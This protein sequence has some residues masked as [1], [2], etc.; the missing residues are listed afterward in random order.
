M[1]GNDN[2][3]MK[4][5][6]NL[7]TSTILSKIKYPFIKIASLFERVTVSNRIQI[8]ENPKYL[9]AQDTT[10]ST[11]ESSISDVTNEVNE[12]G[13]E[14]IDEYN[15]K[16]PLQLDASMKHLYTRINKTGN[17]KIHRYLPSDEN[18][19]TDQNTKVIQ[20]KKGLPHPFLREM[21]PPRI[22]PKNSLLIQELRQKNVLST[23]LLAKDFRPL[24]ILKE[25]ELF[26]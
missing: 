12:N 8:R 24:S 5:L 26:I 1:K 17:G 25:F 4:I 14:D 19:P 6:N 16:V 9:S 10:R 3:T 18:V 2:K 22:P 7:T 21:A 23:S 20:S 11:T 13:Y 15:G